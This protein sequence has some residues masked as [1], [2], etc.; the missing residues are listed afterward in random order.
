MAL[1]FE[2]GLGLAA[3]L[4]GYFLGFSPF[5]G[6]AFG[7]P[8][9]PLHVQAVGIGLVAALPLLALVP[10]LDLAPLPGLSRLRD[11]VH[12]QLV[13]LVKDLSVAQMALVA[14]VAGWGEELLFRGLVQAG[15][16]NW[17]GGNTGWWIGLVVASIFFGLCHAITPSYAILAG[18]MGLYLGWLF[19]FADNLLAPIVTHAVYD[20][21]A[22]IYLTYEPTSAVTE[23]PPDPDS[24]A[25]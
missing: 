16:A 4:L 24:S 2:G 22:L 21:A 14:L 23:A 10:I 18:G 3:L 11:V 8:Q 25:E 12:E 15:T 19:G 9:W 13:P 7:S 20:F 17:F 5:A 6:P 1:L